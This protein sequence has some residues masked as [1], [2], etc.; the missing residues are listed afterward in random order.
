MRREHVELHFSGI[1]GFDPA[2]SPQ[3]V[4]DM[5]GF[6][7]IDSGGNWIR[8][9]PP[10]HT[11]KPVTVPSRLAK[12]MENAA[13]QWPWRMPSCSRPAAAPWPPRPVV[14]G[15]SGVQG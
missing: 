2:S 14:Q 3:N 15:Q 6:T 11:A 12:A 8:I 4:D 9:F 5:A 13:V 1:E 10:P 7:V